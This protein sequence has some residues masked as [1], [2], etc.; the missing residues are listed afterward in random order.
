MANC[1]TCGVPGAYIGLKRVECVNPDCEH[2]VLPKDINDCPCCGG[3]HL[4]THCKV[5]RDSKLATRSDE[6]D[7]GKR[8]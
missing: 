2:F 8:D 4:I 6:K 3:K 7:K 1:P 5:F